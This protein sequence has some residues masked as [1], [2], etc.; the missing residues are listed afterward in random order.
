MTGR[1]AA[2]LML[3]K[4]PPFYID[5][6]YI[7]H[8]K[9]GLLIARSGAS[10]GRAEPLDGDLLGSMLSAIT[11]FAKEAFGGAGESELETLELGD[12]QLFLVNSPTILL[13][14]RTAGSVPAG[15]HAALEPAFIDL[16]DEWGESLR[17]FDGALDEGIEDKITADLRRVLGELLHRQKR[18]FRKPSRKAWIFLAVVGVALGYWAYTA[19][20]EARRIAAIEDGARQLIAGQPALTGYFFTVRYD[21]SAKVLHIR[22]LAP[23]APA[24]KRIEAALKSGLPGIKLDLRLNLLPPPPKPKAIPPLERLEAFARRNS[25]RFGEQSELRDPAKARATARALAALVQRAPGNVR[26]RIVGYTDN[27]GSPQQNLLLSTR[28]AEAAADLL[29]AAGLPRRRLSIAG[30]GT[31]RALTADKERSHDNRR[32]EFELSYGD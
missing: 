11:S 25:I 6:I 15:F 12:S 17:A 18:G 26:L 3:E 4:Y 27:L 14:V 1:S 24:G 8:R 28:R 29:V 32:V 23:D 13:V 30:R 16:M 5:E 10:E 9:T 19:Y 31:L 21:T 7:I 20:A 2:E 22:G